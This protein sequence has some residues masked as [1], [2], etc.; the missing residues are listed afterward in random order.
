MR[1]CKPVPKPV[2]GH[3]NGHFK[4]QLG[5]IGK[6]KAQGMAPVELTLGQAL[7]G[8]GVASSAATSAALG[9]SDDELE[10]IK[11]LTSGKLKDVVAN[12]NQRWFRETLEL[13]Q[14]GEYRQMALLGEMFSEGYGCSKD[15]EAAAHWTERAKKGRAIRGGV[16]CPI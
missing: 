12:A 7:R 16:Y 8:G 14:A 6:R 11:P 3:G 9:S 10:E 2:Q 4:Y 1:T 5:A 15:P 13:S